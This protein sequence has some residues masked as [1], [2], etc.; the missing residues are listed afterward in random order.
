MHGAPDDFWDGVMSSGVGGVSLSPRQRELVELW[1][2]GLVV[3]EDHSWG[4]VDRVVLRV[5]HRVDH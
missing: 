2:P 5:R 1:L 3:E 4:L